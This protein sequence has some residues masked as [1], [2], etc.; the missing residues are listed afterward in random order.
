MVHGLTDWDRSLLPPDEFEDRT[1]VLAGTLA[2]AGC[3][4]VVGF[5]DVDQAGLGAY[6]TNHRGALAMVVAGPSCEPTLFAGFGGGRDIPFI[7]ERVATNDVRPFGSAIDEIAGAL[8]Q[9]GATGGRIGIVGAADCLSRTVYASFVGALGSFDLVALEPEVSRLTR[10]KRP[11]ELVALRRAQ[12]VVDGARDAFV[13]E[14]C[15]GQSLQSALVCMDRQARLLGCRDVRLLVGVSDGSLRPWPD[16]EAPDTWRAGWATVYLAGEY[17]GYWAE[18]GF[19]HVREG[20]SPSTGLR[21]GL[22]RALANTV[23]GARGVEVVAA[24]RDQDRS[25]ELVSA[26][27]IGLRRHEAPDLL[28]DGAA[29]LRSGDVVSTTVKARHEGVVSL[30]TAVHV[31]GDQAPAVPLGRLPGHAEFLSPERWSSS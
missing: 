31:V 25:V 7:R 10:C 13:D 20:R 27:G 30:A 23:A 17:C 19:S 5:D 15:S 28:V 12:S 26:H 14:L 18:S 1:A 9:Q 11:R 24:A 16:E 3:Q 29:R 22:D 6:L 2:E 8:A 21:D 4:A